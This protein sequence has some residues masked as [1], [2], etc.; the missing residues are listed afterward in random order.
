VRREGGKRKKEK[1]EDSIPLFL[2][3]RKKNDRFLQGGRA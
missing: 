2:Q 3:G 1:R